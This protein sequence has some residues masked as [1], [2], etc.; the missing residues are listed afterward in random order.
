MSRCKCKCKG[1]MC[2]CACKIPI[3]DSLQNSPLILQS[4]VHKEEVP[5]SSSER[6]W[7]LRVVPQLSQLRLDAF[8]RTAFLNVWHSYGILSFYKFFGLLWVR[9]L[10]PAVRVRYLWV[11]LKYHEYAVIMVTCHQLESIILRTIRENYDNYQSLLNKYFG[12][13]IK[14]I[15]SLIK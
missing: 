14:L 13:Y 8:T 15:L 11:W 10:K 5:I 6:A 1:K 2:M 7:I 12:G 9:V 4:C 3:W